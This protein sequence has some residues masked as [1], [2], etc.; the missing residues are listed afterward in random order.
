MRV[1]EIDSL[2][3]LSVD[4]LDREFGNLERPKSSPRNHPNRPRRR[5]NENYLLQP[6]FALSLFF[7]PT[8]VSLWN[9]NL[10]WSLNKVFNGSDEVSKALLFDYRN[11]LIIS[12]KARLSDKTVYP[13]HVGI[14][15]K[16]RDLKKKTVTVVN[17]NDDLH[18]RSLSL[19]K[20]TNRKNEA[21]NKI[22]VLRR[23]I[24]NS[25]KQPTN[26]EKTK[27]A[28]T[29]ES[30]TNCILN[31]IKRFEEENDQ[32]L[33]AE[34][35]NKCLKAVELVYVCVLELV[36]SGSSANDVRIP[37]LNKTA[38]A[39]EKV[40]IKCYKEKSADDIDLASSSNS[41]KDVL[42]SHFKRFATSVMALHCD[43][44]TKLRRLISDYDWDFILTLRDL[45]TNKLW[46]LK[47]RDSVKDDANGRRSIELVRS[48][49][50]NDF[51]TQGF[52]QLALSK[53]FKAKAAVNVLCD[54]DDFNFYINFFLKASIVRRDKSSPW[55]AIRSSL[56]N[57]HLE[58]N[59]IAL[60]S[61][62]QH[63]SE[64]RSIFI[65][66]RNLTRLYSMFYPVFAASYDDVFNSN[67]RRRSPIKSS[68][69]QRWLV[70]DGVNDTLYDPDSAVRLSNNLY[71]YTVEDQ[72]V[73]FKYFFYWSGFR[74][75]TFL[76][77]KILNGL[78]L[79]SFEENVIIVMG[80][81]S[82][83]IASKMV[84]LNH[85]VLLSRFLISVSSICTKQPA[86]ERR[87]RTAVR[88]IVEFT[89]VIVKQLNILLKDSNSLRHGI[90]TG[91]LD[92][93]VVKFLIPTV[94]LMYWMSTFEDFRNM[95]QW[96]RK[97]FLD[98]NLLAD[99]WPEVAKLANAVNGVVSECS[100]INQHAEPQ[101]IEYCI[102]ELVNSFGCSP[103]FDK[104][105]SYF[106][107]TDKRTTP[108]VDINVDVRLLC[109]S[110]SISRL[111][112]QGEYLKSTDG[113]FVGLSDSMRVLNP[114][115]EYVDVPS[116]LPVPLNEIIEC[117]NRRRTEVPAEQAKELA[118][119]VELA[120][121]VETEADGNDIV[122]NI[123]VVVKPQ[124][125][126]IDTNVFI[127][128]L[129]HIVELMKDTALQILI[130]TPVL[131]ELRGLKKKVAGEDRDEER[132]RIVREG[133]QK[134]LD[135]FETINQDNVKVLLCNGEV[136]KFHP[137][138]H[139]RLDDTNNDRLIID[140]ARKLSDRVSARSHLVPCGEVWLYRNVLL[141]SKDRVMM[142][143][144]FGHRL[145]SLDIITF[146]RWAGFRRPPSVARVQS[147]EV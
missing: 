63:E 120:K 82:T 128:A 94:I 130:P 112:T 69:K 25:K 34:A 125:I 8:E 49:L 9:E 67:C 115:P 73:E 114:T 5:N 99:L 83:G 101:T 119:L 45:S 59:L 7:E 117:V 26:K 66:L 19:L 29:L 137:D 55:S 139:E 141:L 13:D 147:P 44:I 81:F 65:E 40:Y 98:T 122:N 15:E 10:R 74:L 72:V 102:P 144:A 47:A 3:S 11:S 135:L 70:P 22:T 134:A 90:L 32:N 80:G 121:S 111:A 38:S 142:L 89:A 79:D 39:L 127:D 42:Q 107:K 21:Y 35:V 51:M 116:M 2:H 97:W 140:G 136:D 30:D 41:V 18:E 133:A 84:D 100:Y 103:T 57:N 96:K 64:N 58:T 23:S 28:D 131:S 56:D 113:V 86:S 16:C 88:L 27:P 62:L 60:Y 12:K 68:A 54:I 138:Y 6:E 104:T 4:C 95:E 93:E 118:E 76:G 48:F 46:L 31:L 145:P 105:P 87:L 14:S 91:N 143:L 53:T 20:N 92:S 33:L 17:F 109:L 123:V 43:F 129:P 110:E 85:L 124:Y 132:A 75:F 36:N 61:H 126:V 71:K 108:S 37:V 78:D 77:Y 1:N 106:L 24:D 50:Y 146:Y 52:I